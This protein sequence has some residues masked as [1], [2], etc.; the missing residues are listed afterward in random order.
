[1][2]KDEKG[3]VSRR[4]SQKARLSFTHPSVSSVSY[5]VHP[6]H[7]LSA[8]FL[9]SLCLLWITLFFGRRSLVRTPGASY[10]TR[11]GDAT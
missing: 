9:C 4:V 8:F 11:D 7:T 3:L 10:T 1:M 5:V 6:L 2:Q